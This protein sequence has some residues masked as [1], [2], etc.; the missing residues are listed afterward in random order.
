MVVGKHKIQTF[1]VVVVVLLL[2]LVLMLLFDVFV[3][4]STHPLLILDKV[5]VQIFF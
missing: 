1:K 5:F 3:P 2:L 4:K